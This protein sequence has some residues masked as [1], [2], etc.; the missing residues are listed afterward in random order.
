MFDGEIPKGTLGESTSY[1]LP[2]SQC[3]L[4][5]IKN[6]P[7][8][9]VIYVPPL[10]DALD[11]VWFEIRQWMSVSNPREQYPCHQL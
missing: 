5:Y 2:V 11:I 8:N 4:S 6:L 9:I 3:R 10:V 1:F 7:D